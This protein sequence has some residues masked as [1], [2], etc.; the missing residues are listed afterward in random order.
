MILNPDLNIF[1]TDYQCPKCRRSGNS[2]IP[3]YGSKTTTE[4][5][6]QNDTLKFDDWISNLKEFV[7]FIFI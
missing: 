7:S 2:L 5:Y 4:D 3:F 6:C 1:N